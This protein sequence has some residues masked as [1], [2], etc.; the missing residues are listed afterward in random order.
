MAVPGCVGSPQRLGQKA[1]GELVVESHHLN[2][3]GS[4]HS[5]DPWRPSKGDLPH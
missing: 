2:I 4:L 1:K 5:L 3:P